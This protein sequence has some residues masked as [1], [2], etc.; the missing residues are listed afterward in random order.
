MN[1]NPRFL[2]PR[3]SLSRLL[4][5][6]SSHSEPANDRLAKE[7]S[8]SSVSSEREVLDR[9]HRLLFGGALPDQDA[10]RFWQHRFKMLNSDA[11]RLGEV[12]SEA[13]TFGTD[14]FW[15]A[16]FDRVNVDKTRLLRPVTV[17]AFCFLKSQHRWPGVREAD[18]LLCSVVNGGLRISD[19]ARQ[20]VALGNEEQ[21]GVDLS[22]EFFEAV[23]LPFGIKIRRNKWNSVLSRK[24][25]LADLSVL[26]TAVTSTSL[27][28]DIRQMR[29][30]VLSM[31]PNSSRRA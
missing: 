19:I 2:D 6:Y 30:Y 23:R 20:V 22:H 1:A 14:D 17:I 16:F 24:E 31:T 25:A 4:S 12:M 3:P 21:K 13:R 10:Y 27:K 15:N 8:S 18:S 5:S 11:C 26:R 9:C 7:E 29:S 28:E